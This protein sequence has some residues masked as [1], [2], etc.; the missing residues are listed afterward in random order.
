MDT[1]P[2]SARCWERDSKVLATFAASM[3]IEPVNARKEKEKEKEMERTMEK[4]EVSRDILT[5]LRNR[6]E[7][8]KAKEDS[9]K[10]EDPMI[11]PR[12]SHNNNHRHNRNIGPGTGTMVGI[13]PDQTMDTV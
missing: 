4:E 8:Q 1:H 13:R 6:K 11:N 7:D 3:G 5:D 10:W 2:G 9:M 12:G